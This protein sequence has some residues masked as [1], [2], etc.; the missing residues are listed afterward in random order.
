MGVDF[1]FV[2]ERVLKL[3]SLSKEELYSRGRQ[4]RFAEAKALLCFFAVRELGMTQTQLAQRLGITQ[5]GVASAVVRGERLT[6]ERGYVLL[7]DSKEM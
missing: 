6:R 5:P 7:D 4:K 3:C 1:S 2:E